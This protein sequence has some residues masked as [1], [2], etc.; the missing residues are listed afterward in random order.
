MP[1]REAAES[2]RRTWERACSGTWRKQ[3]TSRP[4]R[5]HNETVGVA[6]LVNSTGELGVTEEDP[7][8]L[9]TIESEKI[10]SAL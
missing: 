2:D 5:D 10:E 7:A 1:G 6:G 8:G 3:A 9:K 4:H